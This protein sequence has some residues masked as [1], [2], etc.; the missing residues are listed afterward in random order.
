M[1]IAGSFLSILL[2]PIGPLV[3]PCQAEKKFHCEK[4]KKKR[5]HVGLASFLAFDILLSNRPGLIA[6]KQ[7][8]QIALSLATD[9][10]FHLQVQH[11]LITRPRRLIKNT[12]R[13]G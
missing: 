2:S 8:V 13:P 4:T 10:F 12:K 1:S 7:F 11:L 6:L 9:H 3:H 5:Q